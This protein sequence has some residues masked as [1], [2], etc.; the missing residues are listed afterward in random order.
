MVCGGSADCS[1]VLRS[2]YSFVGSIPLALV[3]AMAYFSAFSFAIL[4]AFGCAKVRRFLLITVW[5]MLAITL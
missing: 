4:A 5:S 3:G 2:P 1:K